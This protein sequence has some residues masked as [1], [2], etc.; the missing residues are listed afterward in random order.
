VL[1]LDASSRRPLRAVDVK[2][3]TRSLVRS[4]EVSIKSAASAGDVERVIALWV[5][6]DTPVTL[7]VGAAFDVPADAELAVRVR[8]KKTWEH[9][10]DA[11]SDRSE[12][13]LYFA[14]AGSVPVRTLAPGE[15]PLGAAV[16]V[17]SAYPS[18]TSAGAVVTLDAGSPTGMDQR[19]IEFTPRAGW[20]RRYAFDPPI[21]LVAGTRLTL[22]KPGSLVLNVVP[23]VR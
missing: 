13:G 15:S 18:T 10:R 11:M 22:S 8:Y 3:G 5:P 2:P 20:G 21:E 7:P 23:S 17:L 9:E 19:L 6:G 1:S 14:P 4:A 12:I 16:R